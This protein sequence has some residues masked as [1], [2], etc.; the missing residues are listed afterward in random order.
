MPKHASVLTH[1]AVVA[2]A[3]VTWQ[4]ADVAAEAADSHVVP[5]KVWPRL[6]TDK[7]MEKIV[8]DPATPDAPFVIRIRAEAGYIIMPHR[9][10][11]DE[12]IVVLRGTWALGMGERFNRDAL[13]TMEV[14]DF[15]LA[16]KQM[17][18]FALSKTA[19]TL[20]VHGIGPFTS[21]WV[22]PLYELSDKGVFL[23]VSPFEPGT[24]APKTP[25]GCF[26]LK[27]GAHVQGSHGEGVVIGAQCTPDQLTQYRIEKSD[28]EIYW[29]Q[30]DELKAP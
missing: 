17:A 12:N 28:G 29:A 15:G 20:Q 2:A 23:R 14:G 8:G 6:T 4:S 16:P 11:I 30:R 22:V 24:P 25:E 26:P 10:P 13:Q 7:R 5:M 27:L 9:H 19:T 18:H 3:F 1:L 21:H